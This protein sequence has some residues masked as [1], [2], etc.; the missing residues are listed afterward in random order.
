ML[1]IANFSHKKMS[2]PIGRYRLIITDY[3]DELTYDVHF[4]IEKELQENCHD[5]SKMDLINKKR[6][7]YL[8]EI[9]Y[10]ETFNLANLDKELAKDLDSLNDLDK[11]DLNGRLF[12]IFCF[13][14][15]FKFLTRLIIIDEYLTN[16]E[17][18]LF[19][20]LFTNYHTE[21]EPNE[22]YFGLQKNIL[23]D[24]FSNIHT[25]S[26]ILIHLCFYCL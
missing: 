15:E 19:R 25:V 14:V 9:K 3:F 2:R 17:I 7:I 11:T 6:E 18:S 21:S 12:K 10:A 5:E 24:I 4:I 16:E 8:K 26:K 20:C 1:E 13:T 22:S 23:T